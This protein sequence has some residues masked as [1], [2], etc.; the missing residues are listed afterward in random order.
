[1]KKFKELTE[2]DKLEILTLFRTTKENT[3]PSI[4][5]KTNVTE[6][7]VNQVINKHLEQVRVKY[8]KKEP[9]KFYTIKTKAGVEHQ[10]YTKEIDGKVYFVCSNHTTK[11][12]T[13]KVTIVNR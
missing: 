1:M 10:V 3:T 2:A 12:L 9:R 5:K 11:F 4:S 8:H 6:S 7:S 13:S